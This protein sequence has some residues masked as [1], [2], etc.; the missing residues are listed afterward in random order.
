M[1]IHLPASQPVSN[2]TIH[3]NAIDCTIREEFFFLQDAVHEKSMLRGTTPACRGKKKSPASAGL[4]VSCGR[5][6]DQNGCDYQ[7]CQQLLSGQAMQ[8]HSSTEP[9]RT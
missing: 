4:S 5:A 1:D 6:S 3:S 2:A 8:L 7:K 9:G